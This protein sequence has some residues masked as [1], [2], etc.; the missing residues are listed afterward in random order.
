MKKGNTKE[1]AA[2]SFFKKGESARF[3]DL[4]FRK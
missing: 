1:D 2:H 3:I 4:W